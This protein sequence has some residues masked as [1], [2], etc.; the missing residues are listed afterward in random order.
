MK[1]TYRKKAQVSFEMVMIFTIIFFTF[2]GFLAIIKTKIFDITD[3]GDYLAMQ[4]F[5]ENIKSEVILASQVHN[6]YIRWF[7][8][9][10]RL[11]NKEYRAYIRGDILDIELLE[12]DEPIKTYTTILPI[13]V[14]GGFI[15]ELKHNYTD[16][17]ITKNNFDGVRIGRN[18][19][20]LEL[21]D[22]S[23]N[24]I[25]EFEGYGNVRAGSRFYVYV[26]LGCVEDIRGV[27]FTLSFDNNVVKY[28]GHEV[29][30]AETGE[31]NPLF[32]KILGTDPRGLPMR[33]LHP[34]TYALWYM[35]ENNVE[36]VHPRLED[37]F[38]VFAMGGE[39]IGPKQGRDLARI[40]VGFVARDCG[41]GIG[42]VA[43]LTFQ[44]LDVPGEE[45]TLIQ[46]DPEFNPDAYNT[47]ESSLELNYISSS[48]K[49]DENL[50][51]Y[52]CKTLSRTIE[53][54]PD[55]KVDAR[56]RVLPQ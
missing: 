27:Q 23:G 4:N 28:I 32:M 15:E 19:V 11:N 12:L 56:I 34:P 47:I 18:Q 14:K 38:P 40:S 43:K 55:T 51:V 36:S 30:D 3:E 50:L 20:A 39:P 17:C 35:D 13:K 22:F 33:N 46:F 45:E 25:E 26:R 52:D 49:L 6:N 5:G 29:I 2:I 41:T 44:A 31:D 9:P 21:Y 48:L 8:I 53:P 10:Y 54:L 37:Y 42:N 24:P 1:K 7:D 16:H